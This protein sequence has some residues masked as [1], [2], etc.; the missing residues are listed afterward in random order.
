MDNEASVTNG[1]VDRQEIAHFAARAQ[2]WWDPEGSFRP[3]HRLN[4]TRLAFI[5][6]RLARHFGGEPA[7]L[8]PFTGLRLLDIGCGGGLV[9]EPMARLGFRVLGI[10]A[11]A[12][13][14]AVARAHAA[15]AG[16]DIDY[17][18]AAAESLAE[19]GARFDAVLGLEIVEHVADPACLFA[20]LGGLVRPG[21]AFIGATLN[22]TLRAFALAVVGAEY[23]LR[24]LPRGTHDWR[25]FVRPSDFVLGLR[26]NGFEVTELTGLGYNILN[27][28][29]ELSPDLEV[30][31]MIMAIKH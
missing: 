1:T 30:N 14:V 17:R 15:E 6:D 11:D 5:R 22:R 20:A 29:W 26:R 31:Y 21:G 28:K 8:S 13:A 10:D 2:G 7:Q 25:K 3:L 4:P 19:E 24:W 27:S 12:A 16:L 9:C 18:V 23:I